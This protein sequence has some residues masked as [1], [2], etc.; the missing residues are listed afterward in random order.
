M[1]PAA[2]TRMK[3][4]VLARQRL[5]VPTVFSCFVPGFDEKT[6]L[7]RHHRMPTMATKFESAK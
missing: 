4:R 3:Y 1:V 2:K 5:T 7:T 6:T